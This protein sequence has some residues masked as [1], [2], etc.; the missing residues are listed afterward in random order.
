[1]RFHS[2]GIGGAIAANGAATGVGAC[3]TMGAGVVGRKVATA[4]G[5]V[6][7]FFSRV[8]AGSTTTAGVGI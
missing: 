1:M 4:A 2:D 3:T 7:G 6:S 8:P 5:A